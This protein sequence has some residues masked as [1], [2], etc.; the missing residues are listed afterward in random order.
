[1]LYLLGFVA[2]FEAPVARWC[3]NATFGNLYQRGQLSANMVSI[4]VEALVA[5][6]CDISRIIDVIALILRLFYELARGPSFMFS[7]FP[8]QDFTS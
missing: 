2:R 7:V 3:D 5:Y 8:N 6:W 4:N 1:M